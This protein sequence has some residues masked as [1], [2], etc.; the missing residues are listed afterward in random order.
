[1]NEDGEAIPTPECQLRQRESKC[2]GLIEFGDST[3]N[4][5]PRS[6]R[7]TCCQFDSTGCDDKSFPAK[8]ARSKKAWIPYLLNL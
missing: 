1:M 4:G 3:G 8:I 6:H 5:K 7:I 2:F